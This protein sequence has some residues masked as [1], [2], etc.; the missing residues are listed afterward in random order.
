MK[1]QIPSPKSDLSLCVRRADSKSRIP[2]SE[3]QDG[4]R[5]SKVSLKSRIPNPKSEMVPE[6]KERELSIRNHQISSPA[7]PWREK[8]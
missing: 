5:E 4:S 3:V 2:R 8:L 7:R 1:S 6:R